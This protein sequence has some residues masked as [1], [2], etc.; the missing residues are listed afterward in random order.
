MSNPTSAEV[1]TS[2]AISQYV[3][4]VASNLNYK[5]PILSIFNNTFGLPSSPAQGDRYIALSTA[6]TWIKDYIYTYKDATW[7]ADDAI[8]GNT[9]FN[10]AMSQQLVFNGTEWVRIV[11]TIDHNDLANRGI[12]PHSIVD[13]R[14]GQAV[15]TDSTPKFNGVLLTSPVDELGAYGCI[16]DSVSDD[17]A[18][19]NAAIAGIYP[20]GIHGKRARYRA[21]GITNPR[22]CQFDD[23]IQII[24]PISPG[25]TGNILYNSYAFR[26]P[27]WNVETLYGW[28][29]KLHNNTACKVLFTGDSTTQGYDLDMP[30]YTTELFKSFAARDGWTNIT[31]VNSGVSGATTEFWDLNRVAGE[32]AQAPDLYV[33]RWGLNDGTSAT[34]DVTTFITAL[35]SGLNKIRTATPL[36][37][38]IGILVMTPNS[39]S[40]T[41]TCS[42]LWNE[43]MY[44][45]IKQACYDYQC[46]FY[47]TYALHQNSRQSAGLWM[48]AY[49]I[50]PRDNMQ[51]WIMAKL[52]DT[53]IPGFYKNFHDATFPVTTKAFWSVPTGA[54]FYISG[55]STTPEYNKSGFSCPVYTGGAGSVVDGRLAIPTMGY[56]TYRL[57]TTAYGTVP[58]CDTTPQT[59]CFRC[60][61]TPTHTAGGNIVTLTAPGYIFLRTSGGNIWLTT[62][63]SVGAVQINENLGPF[64]YSVNVEYDVELDWDFNVAGTG[65]RLFIN[66]TQFGNQMT[67]TYTRGS[68]PSIMLASSSMTTYW[69]DV[70]LFPSVQHTANFTTT[71]VQA[72]RTVGGILDSN[73]IRSS[74]AT[75]P[76]RSAVI[77]TTADGDLTI[78]S[79]AATTG[80]LIPSGIRISNPTYVPTFV[81]EGSTIDADYQYNGDRTF[82]LTAGTITASTTSKIITLA[83]S[84]SGYWNCSTPVDGG[85]LGCIRFKYKQPQLVAG[86][87][88]TLYQSHAIWDNPGSIILSYA[89]GLAFR[90]YYKSQTNPTA[91]FDYAQIAYALLGNVEYEIALA[92]STNTTPSF[93]SIFIDGERIG[94]WYSAIAISQN[95]G[96]RWSISSSPVVCY[97]SDLHMIASCAIATQA[98]TQITTFY[99]RGYSALPMIDAPI[100]KVTE[101]ILL[102]SEGA[103]SSLRHYERT[104]LALNLAGAYVSGTQL[105]GIIV[106]IGSH[107][108]VTI[109]SLFITTTSADMI[110]TTTGLLSRFRPIQDQSKP[111]AVVNSGNTILG[112]FI[113]TSAGVITIYAGIRATAFPNNRACG[114]FGVTLNWAI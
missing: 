11:T 61:Y 83:A 107:I 76:S 109:D 28:Y 36:S 13:A 19:L 79:S 104:T 68:A 71:N 59:G 30:Y 16:G 33:V 57:G 35:R 113:V 63:N 52:Y 75:I 23:D 32:I 72:T 99:P 89:S 8:V 43:A 87:N 20:S 50:H 85:N 97:L 84:S 74:C 39:S 102:P 69:R 80:R 34:F 29:T 22:G 114:W 45:A 40:Y 70:A 49:Y 53:I 54:T 48:D 91:I 21:T 65:T 2:Q 105:T 94:Q 64:V 88:V 92:W 58:I 82:T 41:T 55:N 7:D 24:Q 3:V 62:N 98:I 18:A 37:S 9:T 6:H 66:G 17:T 100:L 12:M 101:G 5:N 111:A 106:R 108:T 96:T 86:Q 1:P 93:F 25:Q 26:Q 95:P 10:I 15:N 42:N 77:T 38:G 14:L 112:S 73:C 90:L 60:K 78:A 47:D 103:P 4:N 81:A 31:T 46:C 56:A 110:Y 27:I 51:A 67:N 44:P